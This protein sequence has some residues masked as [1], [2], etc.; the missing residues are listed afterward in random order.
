MNILIINLDQSKQRLEFQQ[1]QF[2][3]LNLKFERLPA[4]SVN[5]ISQERYQELGFGWQR[6]LRKVEVAC[7]LSHKN[8]WEKVLVSNQP[9][10]ILE[11]D[12]VLATNISNVLNEIHCEKLTEIDLINF[13]VRSRKKIISKMPVLKL[14][15]LN[16]NLFEL[17]QDRTGAAGY[18]LY[19]SGAK[20]LLERLKN[21]APAIADGFIFS[22]YELKV[23]QV[24]PALIIQE[25]QLEAYGLAAKS[26]FDST[27]GRSEHYKPIYDS[28]DQ[29]KI[30]KRRRII[31]QWHMACRYLQVLFKSQKRF[32]SLDKERFK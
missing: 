30:F 20:K 15:H 18:L 27:I 32:I 11:D 3:R 13:E 4:V 29:K 9:T 14:E 21:T 10:L 2:E 24:E 26:E 1:R 25:D 7:F 5:E 6:P 28:I 31:G 12:A 22:A 23:L 8:A 19:P 16:I 17:Y